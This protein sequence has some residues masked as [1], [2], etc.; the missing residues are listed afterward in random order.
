MDNNDYFGFLSQEVDPITFMSLDKMS[1][2]HRDL[3]E[4]T[5]D[6]IHTKIE[7]RGEA[8]SQE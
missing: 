8:V 1:N 4:L 5:E 7:E 2:E 3:K 6:E